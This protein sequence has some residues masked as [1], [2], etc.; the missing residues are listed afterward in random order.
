MKRLLFVFL[1]TL[2]ICQIA[3][4]ASPTPPTR[5][6]FVQRGVGGGGGIFR[7]AI[8][9]FNP[10]LLFVSCD[11]G[12][13]YRSTDRGKTWALIPSR[14]IDVI[15]ASNTPA[16]F[17]DRIYWYSN[18]SPLV[19]MDDGVTWQN[20][21]WPWRP[22]RKITGMTAY[23]GAKDILFVA[24]K[25]DLWRLDVH[26]NEW[27][28]VLKGSCLAPVILGD[29]IIVTSAGR[30]MSSTDTGKN[31]IM[32]PAAG[33]DKGDVVDIAGSFSGDKSLL[34]TT[35]EHAGIYRSTDKGRRWE[36]VAPFDNQRML[37]IP[38]NQVKVAW[39]AER[40]KFTGKKVWRTDNGGNSWEIAFNYS[41]LR[42]NVEYSWIENDLRWGYFITRSGFVASPTS[43]DVAIV[44]TQ[45]EIFITEDGG[46][47]WHSLV[48][49]KVGNTDDNNMSIYKS[50]GL[51]VTTCYQYQI[52]PTKQ[53][54][55]FISYTDIGFMRSLD[56]GK[57][58]S[59][60]TKGSPW[61]NSFY[62][63]RFDPQSPEIMYAA[64]ASRHDIPHWS[65][66][67][68]P[69]Q[70]KTCNVG[71]V[72]ISKDYGANWEPL[73]KGFPLASCTDVIVYMEKMN[74]ERILLAT[75]YGKGLYTSKDSGR[76]WQDLTP[77][78]SPA[79]H[80]FL[81]LWRNP[82]TASIFC[83][84]TALRENGEIIHG[85][86][87]KSTDDGCSWKDLTLSNPMEWPNAFYVD[88]EDENTI[89][90]ATSS[91]PGKKILQ[92]GVW[93]TTN[94]GQSWE[95]KIDR[96][97]LHF[98][99]MMAIAVHPKNKNIV[100]TGGEKSGL[101]IS[102]DAGESWVKYKD[103]PF[104]AIQ[105]IDFNPFNSDEM[106]VTTYGSGVWVGPSVPAK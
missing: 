52:H 67:G 42:K 1:L 29:R 22:R 53:N 97:K 59:L 101:W 8:S 10:D 75:A 74:K 39:A 6:S 13:T 40:K 49:T 70:C 104:K 102:T 71:G 32:E 87:W 61:R 50:S 96:Q 38:G 73:G 30:I 21:K 27:T 62:R 16:Y 81:R 24:T 86:L 105:G 31:W 23:S 69:W 106:F 4:A 82:A 26:D 64:A 54:M 47:S 41:G 45:A 85:G 11:M 83:L 2:G 72:N 60:S 76:T 34:L 103:F 18:F 79:N 28:M 37:Q 66:L 57:T 80:N 12:G 46:L 55:H 15:A 68:T 90:L 17:R 89:Y 44:T 65:Q 77:E 93:K 5:S 3:C 19:S 51:E 20:V 84:V 58:W 98:A 78:I 95:H 56:Y 88:P 91:I 25:Q 9:P 63:V 100:Y 7:P 48:N 35:I 14:Y 36:K 33:L 94:G 92:G 99:K 43:T